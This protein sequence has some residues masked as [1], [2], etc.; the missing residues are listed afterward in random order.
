MKAAIGTVDDNEFIMMVRAE[1]ESYALLLDG[2]R[3]G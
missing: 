2:Y 3:F 1:T